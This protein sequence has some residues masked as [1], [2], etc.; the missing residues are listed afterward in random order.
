MHMKNPNL[1][2]IYPFVQNLDRYRSMDIKFVLFLSEKHNFS[3]RLLSSWAEE[4]HAG[5]QK[6]L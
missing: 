4:E 1:C 5:V 6:L 2:Y 3:N